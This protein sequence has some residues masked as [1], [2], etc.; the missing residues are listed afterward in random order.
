MTKNQR[1]NLSILNSGVQEIKVE[2]FSVFDF[3]LQKFFLIP[4]CK[5]EFQ[6]FLMKTMNIGILI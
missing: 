3:D 5:E 1:V 4:E 2:D 6:K